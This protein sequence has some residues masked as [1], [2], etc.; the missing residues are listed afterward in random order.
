MHL[1]KIDFCTPA[2]RKTQPQTNGS[3]MSLQL[4]DTGK[5]HDRRTDILETLPG[6][7]GACNV[8]DV[9]SKIDTRVLFGIT[10]C[11]CFRRG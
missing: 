9:R 5:L 2:L 7:M 8:L 6:K 11:C 3:S 10:I 4:F 1:G